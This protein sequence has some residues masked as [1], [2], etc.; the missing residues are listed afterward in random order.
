MRKTAGLFTLWLFALALGSSMVGTGCGGHHYYRVYDPYYT[1]YHVW[2]PPGR[3]QLPFLGTR[4]PIMIRI[5]TSAN[6]LQTSRSNIGLGGTITT[7][8]AS[9][10]YL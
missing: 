10:D 8:M 6:C 5:A 1:D 2:K 4:L 7:I 9:T 3:R